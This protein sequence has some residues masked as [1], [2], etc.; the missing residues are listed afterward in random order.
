VPIWQAVAALAS[1]RAGVT[2]LV[3]DERFPFRSQHLE[4]PSPLVVMWPSWVELDNR[5]TARVSRR[6]LFARDRYTC[7][8][9]GYQAAVNK[10]AKML[11]VDHVKPA[12]LYP[13]RAIAT[14]WDNVVTACF[15]CNQKKGGDLPLVAGM[16]PGMYSGVPSTPKTPS[17]V[18]LRFGGRLNQPQRS[19][20]Q[21]YYRAHGDEDF[22]L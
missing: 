4:I 21:E 16:W 5:D 19:Y 14:S 2:A 12:H 18:Q 13:S 1:Q 17:Y 20:V 9:C 15:A 22:V 11:T 8:Y 7:Q 3:S 6:V 10:A